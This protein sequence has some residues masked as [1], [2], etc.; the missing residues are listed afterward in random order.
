MEEQDILIATDKYTTS[1]IQSLEDLYRVM[2]FGFRGEALASIA[3][4]SELS[5]I[6]KTESMS[7]GKRL[8]F[9]GEKKILTQFASETGTKIEVRNLFYNTPARLNY[10]KT[11]K[12][13]YAHISEFLSSMALVEPE[14][15]FSFIADGKKVFSFHKNDD[16]AYR[17]R[18]IL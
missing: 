17:V 7:F 8:A 16:V 4:V 3:S 12:T 11:E 18:Q 10:L 6:S 13:E 1:K 9:E 5:L 15:A 2:T 14:I